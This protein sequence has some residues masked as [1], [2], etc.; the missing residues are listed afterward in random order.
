MRAW[1]VKNFDP[2]SGF[3]RVLTW[4]RNPEKTSR[5]RSTFYL[6]FNKNKFVTITTYFEESPN[7]KLNYTVANRV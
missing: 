4:I 1:D 6:L 5:I 7:L 2:G 3:E